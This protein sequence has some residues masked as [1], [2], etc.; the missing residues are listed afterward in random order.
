MLVTCATNLSVGVISIL[1]SHHI[2][3]HARSVEWWLLQGS[4]RR[5][6]LRTGKQFAYNIP[7]DD[8]LSR[9]D[10]NN[11]TPPSINSFGHTSTYLLA[12][13]GVQRSYRA[14]YIW[15]NHS[16]D[17]WL[18]DISNGS[19]DPQRIRKVDKLGVAK[20][21]GALVLT[22]YKSPSFRVDFEA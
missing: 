10:I 3:I 8:P 15:I 18:T 2:M 21:G 7:C 20:G 17:Y 5:G 4:Q 16:V 19:T 13:S 9:N 6:R 12:F 22:S 1:F 14:T 11:I